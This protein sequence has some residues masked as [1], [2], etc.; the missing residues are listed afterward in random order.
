LTGGRPGSSRACKI[1][2][3][4]WLSGRNGRRWWWKRRIWRRG[5]ER[6]CS[7][8]VYRTEWD[9]KEQG[10][11]SRANRISVKGESLAK[12]RGRNA[13]FVGSDDEG[14]AVIEVDADG[15]VCKSVSHAVFVAVVKPGDD[16]DR[17]GRGWRWKTWLI[18]HA[19]HL[20]SAVD[21]CPY[22]RCYRSRTSRK[23][24][25]RTYKDG[26]RSDLVL[27]SPWRPSRCGGKRPRGP[28]EERWK[29]AVEA[30]RGSS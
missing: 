14:S 1:S 16:K 10:E 29:T 20:M 9:R 23:R 4:R 22:A 11:V 25:K 27:C 18:R 6:R 19:Q 28:S 24:E 3:R 8:S 15:S 21:R 30:E 2:G 5:L 17:R 26:S 13:L 7:Q 12:G